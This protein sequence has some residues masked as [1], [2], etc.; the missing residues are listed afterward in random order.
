MCSVQSGCQRHCGLLRT[1]RIRVMP[2]SRRIDVEYWT[3]IERLSHAY[4]QGDSVWISREL[5]NVRE[6]RR[7]MEEP[8]EGLIPPMFQGTEVAVTGGSGF[9][10]S[11]VVD[12]LIDGGCAVRVLDPKPPHRAE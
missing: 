10:G 3:T 11:H 4:L 1:P 12:A 6:L 2:D 5:R 7:R 8:A 9:V